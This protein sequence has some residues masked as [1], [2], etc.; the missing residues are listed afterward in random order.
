MSYRLWEL[1]GFRQCL[2]GRIGHD[3]SKRKGLVSGV[4]DSDANYKLYKV[5]FISLQ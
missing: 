3:L 4:P 5:C 2:V 1:N